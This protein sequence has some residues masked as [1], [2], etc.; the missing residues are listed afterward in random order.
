MQSGVARQMME[1]RINVNALEEVEKLRN[2]LQLLQKQH[3]AE[4]E[5]IAKQY[6]LECQKTEQLEVKLYELTD[7]NLKLREE[8]NVV[9]DQYKHKS[10]YATALLDALRKEKAKVNAPMVPSPPKSK[11]PVGRFVRRQYRSFLPP[12]SQHAQA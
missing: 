4:R 10:L 2:Q 3:E 6:I 9:K 5:E 8:I 1:K 11:I 7:N 12:I